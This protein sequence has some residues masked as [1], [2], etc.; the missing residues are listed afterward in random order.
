MID[1]NFFEAFV[2][3][4]KKRSPGI[5]VVMFLCVLI[6][7]VLAAFIG[8]NYKLIAEKQDKIDTLTVDR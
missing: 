1:Y 5:Q 4:K 7:L 8:R 6:L 2:V 3:K